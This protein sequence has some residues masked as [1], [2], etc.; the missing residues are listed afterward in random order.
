MSEN[1]ITNETINEK[2]KKLTMDHNVNYYLNNM[3]LEELFTFQ[4]DSYKTTGFYNLDKKVKGFYNGLYVIGA[5]SSLGKT[6]F[7]HQ[8]ADQMTKSGESVIFFSFEQSIIELTLKSFSRIMVDIK[9]VDLYTDISQND[10]IMWINENFEQLKEEYLFRIDECLNIVD[11][12]SGF[13]DI[14]NFNNTNNNKNNNFDTFNIFNSLYGQNKT[15][16][17]QSINNHQNISTVD[18][19]DA[20]IYNYIKTYKKYP[21]IFIDYLQI[22][23][24]ANNNSITRDNINNNIMALKQISKKYKISVVVISSINRGNYYSNIDF[25]SFKE[26]GEIEYT[27]DVIWGLQYQGMG[28]DKFNTAKDIFLKKDFINQSRIE[29]PRKIELICLKNRFGQAGYKVGF[30][31]FPQYD[32]FMPDDGYELEKK[33]EISSLGSKLNKVNKTKT[34]KNAR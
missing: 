1:K 15:S 10:K 11:Q 31:Y 20:Y 8:L 29:N 9:N 5:M 22:L 27:A 17:M 18:E 12:V 7:I 26:S 34:S 24:N 16:D 32:L 33:D 2:Q 3:F 4:N 21:V 30:D 14:T 19:I 23:K 28:T 13:A 6:T 25:E